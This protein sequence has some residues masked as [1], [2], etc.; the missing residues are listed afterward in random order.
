[1]RP[2]LPVPLGAQSPASL[3]YD[4]NDNP[5]NVPYHPYPAPGGGPAAAD[6][7]SEGPHGSMAFDLASARFG[8]SEGSPPANV[9][10]QPQETAEERLQ[11]LLPGPS[12]WPFLSEL[13]RELS[14]ISA[15]V[16]WPWKATS[17]PRSVEEL[18]REGL[19]GLDQAV[20]ARVASG[21][22]AR[23]AQRLFKILKKQKARGLDLDFHTSRVIAPAAQLLLAVGGVAHGFRHQQLG[24]HAQQRLPS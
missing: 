5:W 15:G 21:S 23:T 8:G 6:A 24:V 19:D 18:A 4:P 20:L 11:W 2:E 16:H 22:D 14:A 1:M 13:E 3:P 7:E 17:E 10:N 12:P 9:G